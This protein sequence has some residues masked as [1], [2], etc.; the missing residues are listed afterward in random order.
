M[1]Q[2]ENT[3]MWESDEFFAQSKGGRRDNHEDD[4]GTEYFKG[5]SDKDDEKTEF[6]KK[7]RRADL[8]AW[9]I[10]FK[11]KKNVGKFDLEAD[12]Y[13][14]GRA[15]F[16]DLRLDDDDQELSR[17]HARIRFDES[18]RQ[19]MYYDC[20]S[21]NGSRINGEDVFRKELKDNDRISLGPFE[22][23]FKKI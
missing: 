7:D 13:L 23:I 8:L 5:D 9:L 4:E 20:G 11:G 16:C 1:S 6:V 18:T 19:Y 3:R 12:D 10:V 14:I 21:A 17:L 2:D 22:A 15:R